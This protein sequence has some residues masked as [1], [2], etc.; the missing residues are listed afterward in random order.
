M[1]TIRMYT[2]D[3]FVHSYDFDAIEIPGQGLAIVDELV[4]VEVD[5]KFLR[6]TTGPVAV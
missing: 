6:T 4:R 2:V 1:V 5:G 3:G